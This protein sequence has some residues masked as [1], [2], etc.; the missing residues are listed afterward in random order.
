MRALLFGGGGQ[1]ASDLSSALGSE[2][3]AFTHAEAD[4]C[5]RGA[6]QRAYA[7]ARPEVVFN[8]AAFHNVDA[9]ERQRENAWRVNVEAV[10]NLAEQGVP[11][12]HF[13][14]NYVFDGR[15]NEPYGEWDVP[16]PRSVY[17]LS[18]LAGEYAALAYGVD[19]LV[20]RTAGLYGLDGTASKGGNFV[21]RMLARARQRAALKV[22]DDQ[23]IQPTFTAD[24]ASATLAA[25]E[26]RATGVVHLT[27][28][29]ECSWFE[30]TKAIMEIAGIE[31]SIEAV[32]T[33]R[34]PGVADR[35]RNGVLARPRSDQLGLPTL[36]AW[37]GALVDYMTQAGLAACALPQENA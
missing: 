28:S 1:L 11:L 34:T 17:A 4:I 22:V 33:V 9:C 5:D 36:R 16:S 35:P 31:A 19:P 26:A 14:T 27:A 23:R 10:Q 37:R 8:C 2:V 7:E 15:R 3:R 30:F 20:I 25:T 21:Q 6:V 29:Q 32:S 24:L 18:K 12:V 13:S